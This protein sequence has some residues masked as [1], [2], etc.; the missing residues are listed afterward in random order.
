M[1]P[2]EFALAIVALDPDLQA[3][4]AGDR[5]WQ[6]TPPRRDDSRQHGATRAAQPSRRAR[7]RARAHR[8]RRALRPEATVQG[9]R[10]LKRNAAPRRRRV[11][12]RSRGQFACG[13]PGFAVRNAR[14]WSLNAA[15]TPSISVTA[16]LCREDHQ[17]LELVGRLLALGLELRSRYRR[18]TRSS[19]LDTRRTCACAA[20]IWSQRRGRNRRASAREP[21]LRKPRQR[22]P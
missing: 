7:A 5:S 20:S 18:G 19:Q 4:Q 12:R 8:D 16:A 17:G 15:A 10:R 13:G 11:A 9:S 14:S 3:D 2:F 6:A 22:K 1:H 21:G